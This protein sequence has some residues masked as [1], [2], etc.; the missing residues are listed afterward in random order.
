MCWNYRKFPL[1]DNF[2]GRLRFGRVLVFKIKF[3]G[4][5][6][7]WFLFVFTVGG[8]VLMGGD[9]GNFFLARVIN[10]MVGNVLL[11]YWLVSLNIMNGI[12]AGQYECFLIS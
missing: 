5:Q 6:L 11:V 12:F 2:W 8:L 1:S 3:K 4:N 9:G 10:L 7:S